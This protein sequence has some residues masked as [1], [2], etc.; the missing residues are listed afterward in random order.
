MP[1]GVVVAS[2]AAVAALAVQLIAVRPRLTRRS[3]AVLAGADGPRSRAHKLSQSSLQRR[4]A[5]HAL[6][7]LRA[8]ALVKAHVLCEWQRRKQQGFVRGANMWCKNSQLGR[9]LACPSCGPR[10]G[11]VGAP[12][13]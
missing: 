10:N 7:A 6:R 3:D 13:A 5:P 1:A 11:N 2:A 8:L 4:M 9:L 12:T